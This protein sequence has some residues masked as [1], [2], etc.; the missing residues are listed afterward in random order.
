[1]VCVRT[2][3]DKLHHDIGVVSQEASL[4]WNIWTGVTVP[5][6]MMELLVVWAKHRKLGSVGISIT[7][8][9]I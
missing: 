3:Q 1:M 2:T 8:N 6:H 9:R 7:A 5:K 4:E